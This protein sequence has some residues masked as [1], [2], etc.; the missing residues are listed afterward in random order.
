MDFKFYY[1]LLVMQELVYTNKRGTDELKKDNDEIKKELNK[2]EFESANIKA[3]INKVIGHNKT[4][5]PDNMYPPNSQDNTTVVPANKKA[6]PL[7]GGNSTKNGG[8]WTLKHKIIST[9]LYELLIKT[10]LKVD[11]ALDLNNFYNHIK[12]CIN[13]VTKLR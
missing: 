4:S 5:F 3:L 9:K 6:S 7:E 8:M 13:E 2:Y 1:H 11:S 10:E 12:M